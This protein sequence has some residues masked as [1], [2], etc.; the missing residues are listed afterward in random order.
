MRTIPNFVDRRGHSASV[1]LSIVC[2]EAIYNLPRNWIDFHL[3]LYDYFFNLNGANSPPSCLKATSSQAA[4]EPNF[5]LHFWHGMQDENVGSL[6]K[7]TNKG[8]KR[9]SLI[10]VQ[11]FTN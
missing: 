2:A 7:D 6:G 3:P 9:I 11:P 1:L 4:R 8:Q 5:V 10:D